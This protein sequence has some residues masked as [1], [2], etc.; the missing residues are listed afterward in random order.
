MDGPRDQLFSRSAF[1]QD[2][3]GIGVLAHFLDQ[4]VHALHLGR[5]PDETR[6]SGARAKLLAQDA[7]LLRDFERA[8]D[9]VEFASELGNV[10]RLCDVVG[11]AHARRLDGAFDRA[12]L[13]Q[14]HDRRL[15]I[16]IANS[17]EQ[18]DA[19]QFGD[20][21]VGEDDVDRILIENFERFLGGGGGSSA[22]SR[23]G[24][25][26]A[27]QIARGSSS[28]TIRTVP[29]HVAVRTLR[30]ARLRLPMF[31]SPVSGFSLNSEAMG[32]PIGNSRVFH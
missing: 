1:A 26:I 22:Q 2:Q 25:Y 28:S 12:V 15:R 8:H 7:V 20:A 16:Q 4:P 10:K 21:Q 17:L 11:R 24:D 27:A 18:L 30:R 32:I 29:G 3:H 5:E 14:D 6:E 19:A 9:A 31:D 23:F 13:R